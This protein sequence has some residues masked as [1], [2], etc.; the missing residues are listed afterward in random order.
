M[1]ILETLKSKTTNLFDAVRSSIT[2]GM[3]KIALKSLHVNLESSAG[4]PIAIFQMVYEK[5]KDEIYFKVTQ[6]D[7]TIKK[8]R[9]DDKDIIKIIELHSTTF[10]NSG[11]TLDVVVL[12]FILSRTPQYLIKAY[13]TTSTGQQLQT[14]IPI[15]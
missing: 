14:E 8:Y 3:A 10:I 1:N 7:S 13:Y 5:A 6:P 4:H 9:Y 11:D 2:P 12:D 15:G